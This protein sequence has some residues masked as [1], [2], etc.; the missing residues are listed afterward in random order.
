MNGKRKAMLFAL[1]GFIFIA[2]LAHAENIAN[3]E[4]TQ[5]VNLGEKLVISGDFNSTAS[6][7]GVLCSTFIYD[8]NN[9]AFP[10]RR[11]TD[12]YTIDTGHFWFEQTINEPPF[13]RNTDYNAVVIC[14]NSTTSATFSVGQ[15]SDF[16]K[17]IFNN[18][19]FAQSLAPYIPWI[20][21]FIVVIIGIIGFFV[22][23]AK[24]ASGG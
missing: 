24:I 23:W 18:L 13:S 10:F 16:S 19:L 3:L 1:F 17:P 14:H 7:S 12:E 15:F 20:I 21:L 6:I 4:I 5:T 11:L 2:S 9:S 22:Y 8:L